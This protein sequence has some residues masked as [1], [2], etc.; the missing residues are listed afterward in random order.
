MKHC[1]FLGHPI[2]PASEVRGRRQTSAVVFTLIGAWWA[3]GVASPSH[4]H[5]IL[6]MQIQKKRGGG[7]IFRVSVYV[8]VILVNFGIWHDTMEISK[9]L[10]GTRS[11]NF[12]SGF[13]LENVHL[14]QLTKFL[15]TRISCGTKAVKKPGYFMTSC[16]KVGR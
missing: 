12:K 13:Q 7:K 11:G 4:H 15:R 8:I 14:H 3:S 5:L 6:L 9:I 10:T 1:F 16:K 2:S